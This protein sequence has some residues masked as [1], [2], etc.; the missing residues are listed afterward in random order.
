MHE[1]NLSHMNKPL[2]IVFFF[3]IL[4]LSLM[5][6]V[7]AQAP[8]ENTVRVELIDGTRVVGRIV[9][10]DE[11]Q[12]RLITP[13]GVE[14]T[15]P[16]AQIRSMIQQGSSRYFREDPNHSRL[17][18]SPTAR[19][20]AR[21]RAYLADYE[22]FFPYFG[23]GVGA[24][25]TMAGGISII[26]GAEGQIAYLAPKLTLLERESYSIAGG[27]LANFYLGN[28]D[29]DFPVIGLLYGV[30]TLGSNERA[31]TIGL[32]YAFADDNLSNS[33]VLMVGGEWQVSNSVKFLTENFMYL[34]DADAS[35]V[36]GGVRFF[37]DRLAADLGLFT[38]P[39]LLD[40]LDGFPFIPWLGFSYVV[41]R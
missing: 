5:S 12:I 8:E 6:V 22:L 7:Q 30:G 17:F 3:S 9:D 4:M 35:L 38:I 27:V 21:G 33:P 16:R 34:E 26:P 2:M 24:G 13:A 37:G 18:F 1:P 31:L 36:S 20:L 19:P 28:V 32:A 25:V 29:E 40:E 15:I 10:E 39:T 23:Y 11:D 14:M 41:R